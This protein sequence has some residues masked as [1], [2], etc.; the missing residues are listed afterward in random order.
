MKFIGQNP[1]SLSEVRLGQKQN[2]LPQCLCTSP[3][4]KKKKK[5]DFLLNRTENEQNREEQRGS[6]WAPIPQ[7]VAARVGS[8]ASGCRE[9]SPTLAPGALQGFPADG[10]MVTTMQRNEKAPGAFPTKD[11]RGLMHLA[12][13]CMVQ[14]SK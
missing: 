14:K 2:L 13:S 5:I 3:K 10:R 11:S 12:H 8:T 7:V 1:W 9:T 6:E 4:K